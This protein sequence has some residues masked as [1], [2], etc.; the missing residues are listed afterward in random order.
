MK[1]STISN[2]DND[3]IAMDKHRLFFQLYGRCQHYLHGFL[4]MMVHSESDAEDL[5]QETA[6]TMWEH[7]DK[8]QPGTNFAAWG[9]KIAKSKAI[10]FI[11]RNALTRPHLSA[12]LYERIADLERQEKNDMNGRQDALRRCVKKLKELDRK[13]LEIHYEQNAGMKKMAEMY[14]RSTTG[15]YHTMARIHTALHKCIQRTLGAEGLR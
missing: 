5:L 1:D 13:F 11:K 2:C 6:A 8:F 3:F 14:G 9:F 12:H 10:N 7:F 4:F 15:I